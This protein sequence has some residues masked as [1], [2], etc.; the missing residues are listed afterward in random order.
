MHELIHAAGIGH[1]KSR[2]DKDE[3]IIINWANIQSGMEFRVAW[4]SGN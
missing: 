1:E 3:H 4:S 2:A